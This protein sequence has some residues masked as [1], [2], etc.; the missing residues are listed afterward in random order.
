ME[1]GAPVAP[2]PGGHAPPAPGL[3]PATPLGAPGAADFARR[4]A[5]AAGLP[6]QALAATTPDQLADQLG[7]LMRGVTEDVMRLMSAR[8]EARRIARSANQTMIQAL[9]NNPLK[10]SPSPDEALRI[11]FGPPTRSYLDANR[12][13]AASFSDLKRHQL[14]TFRAMQKALQMLIEDMAP[15]AI[16]KGLEEERGLASLI[17]SS[18]KARAW[19]TYAARWNAKALRQD[20][21]MLGAF[22]LYFAQAYDEADREL[23]A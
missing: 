23:G 13:F 6:E 14:V 11:M 19:E 9:D 4:F 18:R 2:E 3:P 10:F 7:R 20:D 16:E 15:E 21:G 1:H 8:G 17:G 22:M 5:R 12:A